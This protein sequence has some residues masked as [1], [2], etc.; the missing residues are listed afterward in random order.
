[1]VL[2]TRSKS[3]KIEKMRALK[4]ETSSNSHW[5]QL[6]TQYQKV[7]LVKLQF[8]WDALVVWILF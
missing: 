4:A 7:T 8:P 1:M 6:E 5:S 3:L 2:I